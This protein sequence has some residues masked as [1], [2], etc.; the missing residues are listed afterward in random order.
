MGKVWWV[1]WEKK[2]WCFGYGGGVAMRKGKVHL[3][4]AWNSRVLCEGMDVVQVVGVCQGG[5]ASGS[6]E[7]I[8]GEGGRGA[9][10]G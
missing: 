8:L 2:V 10:G 6:W 7:L 5:G 9:Q 4:G 1:I 3:G